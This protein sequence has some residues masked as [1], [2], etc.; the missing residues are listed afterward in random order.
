MAQTIVRATKDRENP[1]VMI[2]KEA[3]S[4]TRLSWKARGLLAYILSKP[5]DWKVILEHLENQAPDGKTSLRSGIDELK[6]HGYVIRVAVRKNKKID[7]WEFW[8]NETPIAEP[9]EKYIHIDGDVLD[10]LEAKGES[11]YIF[12]EEGKI[13]NPAL[14]S[15]NRNLGKTRKKTLDSGNLNQGFQDQGNQEVGNKKLLNND[16]LNND[17]TNQSNKEDC[18]IDS[19]TKKGAEDFIHHAMK[20]GMSIKSVQ[21]TR[22]RYLE[23]RLKGIEHKV[24]ISSLDETYQRYGENTSPISVIQALINNRI[25]EEKAKKAAIVEAKEKEERRKKNEEIVKEALLAH[26]INPA[27]VGY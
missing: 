1:Y 5:N 7:H 25:A 17:L 4:D 11:Q 3:I 21:A 22:Q 23:A 2:N 13:I 14:L 6:K 12:T 18:L 27:E 19:Q 26:G 16:L 20:K 8:V 10:E 9:I 15:E 24:L